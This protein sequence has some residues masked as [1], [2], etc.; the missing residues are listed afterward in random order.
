[1]PKRNARLDSSHTILKAQTYM[2]ITERNTCLINY[3]G[4]LE[5][6]NKLHL[7]CYLK[8]DSFVELSIK[9]IVKDGTV[10]IS[11]MHSAEEPYK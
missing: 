10:E 9:K 8:K 2:L 5:T 4:L 1:M 6:G 11:E 7:V 3:Q